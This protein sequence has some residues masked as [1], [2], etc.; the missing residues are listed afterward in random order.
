LDSDRSDLDDTDLAARII[1]HLR[2]IDPK[3]AARMSRRNAER[4]ASHVTTTFERA[5]FRPL[6][7]RGPTSADRALRQYFACYGLSSPAR[8]SPD[9][10]ATD[11]VIAR[12]F[13]DITRARPRAS[14]VYLWAPAANPETRPELA[15]AL[16]ARPRRGLEV[17]WIP[18]KYEAAIPRDGAVARAVG[19]AVAIRT[20]LA[21]RLGERAVRRAGVRVEHVQ[22]RLVHRPTE[23]PARDT[24]DR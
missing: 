6:E 17:R 5:P 24:G 14:L 21:E 18:M 12:T 8:T 4:L 15:K 3:G 22:L 23:P 16:A 9:W 11:L 20:R 2:P 13:E 7:V 10:P 19:E 1:E